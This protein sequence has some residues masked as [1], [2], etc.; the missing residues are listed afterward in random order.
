MQKVQ[1]QI[2]VPWPSNTISVHIINEQSTYKEQGDQG[3]AQRCW[4]RVGQSVYI[5]RL[6]MFFNGRGSRVVLKSG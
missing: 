5:S 2:P 4:K 3:N 6:G 1:I